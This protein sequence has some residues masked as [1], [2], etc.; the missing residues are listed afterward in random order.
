MKLNGIK[1]LLSVYQTRAE[2]GKKNKSAYAHGVS[3]GLLERILFQ[4]INS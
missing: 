4:K 3:K 1:F 2:I